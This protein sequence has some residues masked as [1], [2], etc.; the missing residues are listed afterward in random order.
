MTFC[1]AITA[2]DGRK[3]EQIVALV[4]NGFEIYQSCAASEKSQ[5]LDIQRMQVLWLI[6]LQSST[7]K[8]L[9]YNVFFVIF[10]V[11]WLSTENQRRFFLDLRKF[12]NQWVEKK[13]H[14][15]ENLLAF[16]PSRIYGC[17]QLDTPFII[18]FYFYWLNSLDVIYC[19]NISLHPHCDLFSIQTGE[20][21]QLQVCKKKVAE[22]K[23]EILENGIRD[24]SFNMT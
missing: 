6:K 16:S 9:I 18:D 11:L 10:D 22:N 2:G 7:L 3:N 5:F 1:C 23:P 4:V 21:T 12:W 19:S 17:F 20:K 14:S 13:P 8:P 15:S 24:K